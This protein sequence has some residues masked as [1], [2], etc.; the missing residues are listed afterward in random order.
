MIEPS[1]IEPYDIEQFFEQR[2]QIAV[3]WS[4]EDV[5]QV[6]PDLTDDQAWEVLKRCDER[7]ECEISITWTFI[8]L[9]AD[10]MFPPQ[11]QETHGT[12]A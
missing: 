12:G 1:D 11:D 6:R 2:R 3:I 9:I 5:R 7:K 4:T 10:E 8:E